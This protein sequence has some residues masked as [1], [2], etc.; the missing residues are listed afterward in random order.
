MRDQ[1][2]P[3]YSSFGKKQRGDFSK[4]A[5]I[6]GRGWCSLF[7]KRN[8]D[9]VIRANQK[10]KKNWHAHCTYSAFFNMYNQIEAA[11]LKSGNAQNYN[12]PAHMDAVGNVADNESQAFRYSVTVDVH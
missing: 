2:L 12:T 5:N 3:Y 1:R 8:P 6:L 11:L 4:E 9:V 10:F 7:K